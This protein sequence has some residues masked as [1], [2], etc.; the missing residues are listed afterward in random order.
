MIIFLNQKKERSIITLGL[1]GLSGGLFYKLYDLN[2]KIN[3]I[4]SSNDNNSLNFINKVN[5]QIKTIE[6]E[7][8]VIENNFNNL[9]DEIED[10]KNKLLKY[11]D[12]YNNN[13]LIIDINSDKIQIENLLKLNKNLAFNLNSYGNS[14]N[15]LHNENDTNQKVLLNFNSIK[16]IIETTITYINEKENQE[17]F[18]RIKNIQIDVN[19]LEK[20]IIDYNKEILDYI[21]FHKNI[22]L[23]NNDDYEKSTI[24]IMVKFS[25]YFLDFKKNYLLI[26][27]EQILLKK[28]LDKLINE[29][30][31]KNNYN[32]SLIKKINSLESLN[33]QN[34][35]KIDEN[36]K[37]ILLKNDTIRKLTD[38]LSSTNSNNEELK[39]IVDNVN[40][41]VDLMKQQNTNLLNQISQKDNQINEQKQIIES[42]QTKIKNLEDE[43]NTMKENISKL[44]LINSD[45]NTKFVSEQKKVKELEQKLDET[46]TSLDTCN[47]NVTSILS[48]NSSK[49]ITILI[50]VSVKHNLK[51][52]NSLDTIKFEEQ[53]KVANY[54]E[55]LINETKNFLIFK[56][57]NILPSNFTFN[58]TN[59]R[60]VI[61]TF[62]TESFLQFFYSIYNELINKQIV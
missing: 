40:K 36:E 22:Y 48:K 17:L 54:R 11:F 55:N 52:L 56:L 1:L 20:K 26:S 32:E 14:I 4:K 30:N 12:Y 6:K 38:Q 31:E 59:E 62:S 60:D 21:D 47:L 41:T 57:F 27:D 5:T 49:I 33:S 2:S 19:N 50:Q 25:N 53:L 34:L 10:I 28:D 16:T 61:N 8:N 37:L 24:D 58:L 51:Y 23:K 15:K 43:I 9:L 29:L 3:I 42:Q 13:Y 7:L 46:K 45:L 44:L 39:S 35:M 18:K